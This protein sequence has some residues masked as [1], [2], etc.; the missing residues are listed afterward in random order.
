VIT[1]FFMLGLLSQYLFGKLADQGSWWAATLYAMLPDWQLFWMADTLNKGQAGV[2]MSYLIRA[3]GYMAGYL[4]AILMVA[5]LLFEER[6][7][8]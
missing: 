1:G 8:S 7:L 2:P 5:A 6:E 3:F 4:G